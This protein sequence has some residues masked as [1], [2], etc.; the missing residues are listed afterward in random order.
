[1]I[2]PM[3][4]QDSQTLCCHTLY[5]LDQKVPVRSFLAECLWYISIPI[6]LPLCNYISLV[7]F[8]NKVFFASPSNL[9]GPSMHLY[10]RTSF[11][12]SFLSEL[13]KPLCTQPISLECLTLQE[14]GCLLS[15]NPPTHTHTHGTQTHEHTC[16]HVHTHAHT[17]HRYTIVDE[18]ACGHRS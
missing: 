13:H 6:S 4:M 3:S 12:H 8:K 10:V 7:F 15:S 2:F 9:P 1:M 17:Q 11:N 18:V 14:P 5:V 16:M